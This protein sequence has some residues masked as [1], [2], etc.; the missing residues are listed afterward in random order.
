MPIVYTANGV[1]LPRGESFLH[2]EINYP[3]NWLDLASPEDLAAHG[4]FAEDVPTPP[5]PP[6][7]LE[8]LNEYLASKRYT[9]ETSGIVLNGLPVWTDRG[10]QGMLSRVVQLLDRGTL[11][12]PLNIKTPAGHLA[13]SAEQIGAIGDAVALHVQAAFDVEATVSGQIINGTIT[14][15]AQIDAANWPSNS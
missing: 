2:N 3:A 6:P 12:P 13:L 11:T 9:I 5:A 4:I 1:V 10:T 8:A 15:F 7:T 14:T